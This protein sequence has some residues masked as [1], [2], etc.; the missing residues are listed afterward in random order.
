M[1]KVKDEKGNVILVHGDE[2]SAPITLVKRTKAEAVEILKEKN[3]D[4]D[5]QE[6]ILEALF[7][8]E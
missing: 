2:D 4:Q 3:I 1:I 7:K 5:V 6:A 8:E